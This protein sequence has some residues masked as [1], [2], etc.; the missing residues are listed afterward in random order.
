M[1][2]PILEIKDVTIG[3]RH[4][5]ELNVVQEGLSLQVNRGEMVCLIGPNGCGKSTLLRTM[6]GMQPALKGEV[7][8]EGVPLA[9]QSLTARS[10]L[11]AA[12]LTEPI[13]VEHLTVRQLIALGRNPYTNWL[14]KLS[15]ADEAL[16]ENAM[17][18]VHMAHYA[19]RPIVS[20]SD[21]E[22]QRALIAK[23]LAQ[24]TPAILLDEPTAHL[25]LPNRVDIMILLQQLA[26]QTNKAI[27]LSTHELD[28]AIQTSDKLWL[29]S[30]HGGIKIGAP[31]DLILSN[32]LQMVFENPS[33]TFDNRSG[34][35][36]LDHKGGR[37]ISLLSET[38][39]AM[40]LWTRRALLRAGY[41]MAEQQSLT[42][43]IKEDEHVWVL[44]SARDFKRFS[45]IESL[46]LALST[47][48]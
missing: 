10:R 21:G 46:L 41:A 4:K 42:V 16:I 44:S 12:V 17:E 48:R 40:F 9:Q 6:M 30:P 29:M 28:L 15:L 5:R 27:I 32:Q 31:E 14:G 3:Y 23:A 43:Q 36:T 13:Q 34:G 1:S 20:L 8:V 45:S 18:Q 24:D 11:I 19:D 7:F 37:K 38:K 35:F 2:A 47:L 26:L 25:D 33:Y 39:G 22:R